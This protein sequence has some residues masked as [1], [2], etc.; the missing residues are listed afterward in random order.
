MAQQGFNQTNL[1][2]QLKVVVVEV[3]FLDIASKNFQTLPL[4]RM[5]FQGAMLVIGVL[6]SVEGNNA[7]RHGAWHQ[8]G[9]II[10]NKISMIG[11]LNRHHEIR[12]HGGDWAGF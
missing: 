6:K 11:F 4:G 3:F 8:R 12:S 1:V 5:N 7:R 9:N 2:A 10:H